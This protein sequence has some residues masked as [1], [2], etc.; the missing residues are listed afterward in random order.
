METGTSWAEGQ[1]QRGSGDQVIYYRKPDKGLEAK[2]ITCGD[3]V[4]GSKHLDYAKRGF[5]PL[6]KYGS[7]NNIQ[8]DL[9]AFGS[10]SSPVAP[11]FSNTDSLRAERYR[12]EQILTHPDGSA[13]FP[14]D[15]IIAY[16]WYRPEN[17]PVTGVVFPQLQGLKIREYRCPERCGR[18]PF[19]DIDGIGGVTNLANHLRI[20][21]E[22]DRVSIMAYGERVGIDFNKLDVIDLPVQDYEPDAAAAAADFTCAECG[23]TFAGSMAKARYTRHQ[24][25]HPQIEIEVT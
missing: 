7:V 16:S 8:R 6:H 20:S 18:P 19:V 17:V 21:H 1:S 5:E 9:R 10:K 13:E 25:N 14:I 3:S 22:W 11:E 4:S 24:N 15:Q 23:A 2:W 12:W